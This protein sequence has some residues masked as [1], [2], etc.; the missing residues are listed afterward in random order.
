MRKLVLRALIG[1]GAV[2]VSAATLVSCGGGS[3][4]S[5][6]TGSSS[7]S[8][9]ASN[10][11]S[12]SE[13]V[14]TPS[15]LEKDA[16]LTISVPAL[17]E[18]LHAQLLPDD[19]TRIFVSI[20]QYPQ[21]SNDG[22][23]CDYSNGNGCNISYERVTLTPQ[24]PKATISL[25]PGYTQICLSVGSDVTYNTVMCGIAYLKPGNNTLNYTLV[26][27]TWTLPSGKDIAGFNRFAIKGIRGNE[28]RFNPLL[29]MIASSDG[30]TWSNIDGA[31]IQVDYE[32]GGKLFGFG[33]DDNTNR[34]HG[35]IAIDVNP[36]SVKIKGLNYMYIYLYQNNYHG[37]VPLLEEGEFSFKLEDKNGVDVTS[38]ILERC[39]F[40]STDGKSITG[41]L[42][43]NAK[44]STQQDYTYKLTKS[45]KKVGANIC[46]SDESA[47]D[48][49][50]D[51]CY[52]YGRYYTYDPNTRTYTYKCYDPLYTYNSEKKRC[53][54]SL[55]NLC[56]GRG[57][58]Y[59]SDT[60]SCVE[61]G[62]EY[63][64]VGS[65]ERVTITGS[66]S[67]PASGSIT[68]QKK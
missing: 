18:R 54:V 15:R 38:T 56:E 29:N 13:L 61:T 5:A 53:E 7:S 51:V 67:L 66:G 6:G 46:Y 37:Y 26:R 60:K 10:S 40:A 52:D 42:I 25:F 64:S 41:C 58:T 55:K 36:Q 47:Y 44:K 48:P 45:F 33:K 20:T 59:N 50:A 43:K 8:S 12:S 14:N 35:F 32:G 28:Y 39:K 9:T 57:G 24:N 68:V 62:T 4:S 2:A 16:Y 27:G 34:T 17:A 49:S 11:S 21:V 30:N 31:Y 3:N 19:T 23:I 63:Y 1:L 22:V 65:V